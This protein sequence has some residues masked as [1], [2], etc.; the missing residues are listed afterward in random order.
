MRCAVVLSSFRIWVMGGRTQ[1]IT[2]RPAGLMRLIG[3]TQETALPSGSDFF[4]LTPSDKT[5]PIQDSSV[6][7][8]PGYKEDRARPFRERRR[9]VCQIRKRALVSGEQTGW[10]REVFQTGGSVRW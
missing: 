2:S 7:A 8:G 9:G 6:P 3:P 10:R 5:L 1:M 4:G